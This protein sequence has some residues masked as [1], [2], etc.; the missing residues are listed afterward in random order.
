MKLGDRR[1]FGSVWLAA[2]VAVGLPLAGHPAGAQ[3]ATAH[4]TRQGQAIQQLEETLLRAMRAGSRE[5]LERL[6]S[7]E[8]EMTVAQEPGSPV[9][10]DLWI[11]AVVARP[12]KAWEIEQISVR[13]WGPLAVASFLLRPSSGSANAKPPVF[14][15][16]TWR[17]EEGHWRLLSRHAALAV[18]ARTDIPGDAAARTAPKKY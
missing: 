1:A 6:L 17:R 10:R 2:L 16:D 15:V 11:D 12:A 18:G 4:A 9:D 5:Q 7:D 13:D 14:V 8:F 3:P